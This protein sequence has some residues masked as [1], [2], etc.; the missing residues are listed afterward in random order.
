M[1]KQEL[2]PR[3][4]EGRTNIYIS[5]ELSKLLGTIDTSCAGL[6]KTI[7]YRLSMLEIMLKDAERAVRAKISDEQL[8]AITRANWSTM[9]GEDCGGPAMSD[10]ATINL[11]D[12]YP[13]EVEL[14]QEEHRELSAI[15]DSLTVC[16]GFALTRMVKKKRDQLSNNEN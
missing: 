7:H 1:A 16:E 15:L 2:G 11:I 3:T 13:E 14:S 6:S 5:P 4:F 9:F 10:E 12:S 8:L